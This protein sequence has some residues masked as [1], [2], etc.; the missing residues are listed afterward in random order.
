M[1]LT[2]TDDKNQFVREVL[3]ARL[4]PLGFDPVG[5]EGS[6]IDATL[7]QGQYIAAHNYGWSEFEIDPLTQVLTVTTYGV[8]PYT[9]AELLADPTIASRT[10]L[11]VSQFEVRPTLTP[12]FAAAPPKIRFRQG[13]E[14]DRL[15]G[16]QDSD[17]LR[18]TPNND[19]LRGRAGNDR[20]D[21]RGAD[22]RLDGNDGNDRLR[23]GAGDDRLRG[24]DGRD[25]LLGQKGNDVLIGGAGNDTLAGGR[26]TDVF[27]YESVEDG[28]DRILR[29]NV[30]Q[31]LID[32]STIFA[33]EAFTGSSD[34]Q[35]FNDYVSLVENNRGTRLII[36]VD[37]SGASTDTTVLALIQDVSG[38]GIQN[39]VIS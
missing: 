31:D 28:R 8:E 2:D 15:F 9:E 13:T 35:R 25:R 33:D 20:L 1:A 18:G 37:G 22:D 16:S 32:L 36:D 24:Q 21:G 30:D 29:F 38:L 14:G 3:D 23:G 5:L 17:R 19:V 12:P 27:V 34:I 10:P 39:F 6:G 26:G 4:T 7:L 11:I